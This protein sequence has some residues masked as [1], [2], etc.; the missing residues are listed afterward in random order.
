MGVGTIRDNQGNWLCFPYQQKGQLV[1]RKYRMTSEKQHKMDKGGK[2]VLWNCEVLQSPAVVAGAA[3]VITEGEFD[4]LI[5][6]QCGWTHTVSVPNG[7]PSEATA[8]LANSNR[9][10]FLFESETELS[11]VA[12]FILAGDGDAPGMALNRDLAAILG[13][14]RCSFVVYP[15]G[16]KDLNEVFLT[17][18]ESAVTTL[19]AGAKAYPVKGLYNFSDFPDL[20][21][22][23]S[24]PTG[25][26][27]LD[28]LMKIVPGTMTVFTGYANMGKSTVLDTIVANL[29]MQNIKTCIASFETLVKPILRDG[30][31]KALIG[32]SDND[33]WQHPQ[34]LAAWDSIESHVKIISNSLDEDLEFDLDEFLDLV[35]VSV[36]RDGVKLVI[37]D[38]WNEL[39]HKRGRDESGTEYVGRAIRKIKNFIRRYNVAFW[40]V[41]HPTK[42]QKGVNSPPGLYDVSDSA[43]WSNKADYGLTYHRADKSKN[44][45][46][47]IVVK[48]RK[49][50]PGK[51]DKVPVYFDHRQSRITRNGQ[52][53]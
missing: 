35:R 29:I 20:P 19:L 46:E 5:A 15:E 34:R 12:R 31:S 48:V 45:G 27:C 25:I 37:L 17:Y 49:G 18:G 43:N 6:M 24:F 7:A 42:P 4:A 38:P 53:D 9:Y 40:V 13:A 39:E 10:S 50:L 28:E 32:C 8:D 26:V 41:A 52:N 2:L 1:N 33:Y 22:V 47:L 14:E 30:L 16:T 21:E 51:C 36:V 11:Q 23:E 44:E 3:V